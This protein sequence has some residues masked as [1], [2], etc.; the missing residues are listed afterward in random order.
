MPTES[1]H[2][3]SKH[4]LLPE[5]VAAALDQLL[6][7]EPTDLDAY[8]SNVASNVS[9]RDTKAAV[10]CHCVSCD[11]NGRPRIGDL[12]RAVALRIVDYAIPRSEIIAARD[13]DTRFNTTVK[14]N[15][16]RTKAAQLF[17][18]LST[19]GEGGE[20]LLYMLIQSYLK[21]PQLLCK[22]PLKTSERMHYHGVD[23]V[24]A[25]VDSTSNKLLLYWGESK[26]HKS[27]DNAISG[28][29]VSLRDYLVDAGGSGSPLQRD[30]HLIRDNLDLNDATLEE[31]LL[32]LLDPNNPAFNQIEYRGAVLIGFDSACYPVLPDSKTS[33]QVCEAVKKAFANWQ[34][35][36]HS[37]ILD[38]SPLATFTLEVFLLPFPTVEGFRSA[39]LKELGHNV[40]G[41]ATAEAV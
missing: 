38:T 20:L 24:H 11:G 15:E 40:K 17:T 5:V 1:I 14:A 25:T 36:V 18:D 19:T 16:L 37:K 31:A 21:I 32:R 35:K 10:H 41:N 12:A 26:L 34:E 4:I 8:L 29:C 7:G 2:L 23:G 33:Q 28:C 22:M 39:F 3:A 30:L 6:R 9:L 27:I 13:Y